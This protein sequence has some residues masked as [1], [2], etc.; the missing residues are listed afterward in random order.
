MTVKRKRPSIREAR[1]P[2]PSI[3]APHPAPEQPVRPDG[4]PTQ[5]PPT[6]EE[7][8]W[9]RDAAEAKLAEYQKLVVEIY[10]LITTA[11]GCGRDR[12]W[13][14]PLDDPAPHLAKAKELLTNFDSTVPKINTK[15]PVVT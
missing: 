14:S 13:G 3:P 10:T 4:A 12:S 9:Y 1:P 8:K 2:G 11:A 6:Y 15:G 5:P 7:L